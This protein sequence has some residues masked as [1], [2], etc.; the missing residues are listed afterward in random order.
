MVEP[1]GRAPE[2]FCTEENWENYKTKKKDRKRKNYL[3]F[4][5]K[6]WHMILLKLHIAK[7]KKFPNL[8]PEILVLCR[9][10]TAICQ[11]TYGEAIG[12]S[13]NVSFMTAS[14]YFNRLIC[15][16]AN[17][18][19]F[20]KIFGIFSEFLKI[21]KIRQSWNKI[22]SGNKKK[23]NLAVLLHST[24][25]FELLNQLGLHIRMQ[26]QTTAC[27]GQR[28]GG[29]VKTVNFREKKLGLKISCVQN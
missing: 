22:K 3:F 9:L 12:Q 28:V 10:R 24:N 13:R 20:G 1:G 16:Y 23:K 8:S 15:S 26:C 6:S 27:Q 17:G 4:L 14:M 2:I 29:G 11:K 19:I 18:W 5:L 7:G 25:P 21:L